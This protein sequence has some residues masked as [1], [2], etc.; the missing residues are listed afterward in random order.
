MKYFLKIFYTT[1]TL[2]YHVDF[3]ADLLKAKDLA[4]MIRQ[5][6]IMIRM[7]CVFIVCGT[8]VG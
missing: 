1:L 2:A 8:V 3:L 5:K 4:M 7:L 6:V